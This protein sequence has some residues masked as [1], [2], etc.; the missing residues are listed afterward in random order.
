MVIHPTHSKVNFNRFVNNTHVS[1]PAQELDVE[2]YIGSSDVSSNWWGAN[3]KSN[4]KFHNGFMHDF[5]QV[6]LSAGDVSTCDINKCVNGFVPLSL[7]YHFVLNNSNDTGDFGR[8]PDFNATIML[9][10]NGLFR[11]LP[12]ME[13][14]DVNNI[15]AK[16]PWNDTLNSAGDYIFSGLVD[17]QLLNINITSERNNNTGL[18]IVKT[19][20]SSNVSVGDLVNYTINVSNNGVTN[21]SQINVNDTLNNTI[22]YISS[23]SNTGSYNSSSGL[24]SI[25]SLNV[26]EATILNINVRFK[27]EGTITNHAYL[28]LNDSLINESSV[29]VTANPY[30]NMGNNNSTATINSS[31]S[32]NGVGSDSGDGFF[33]SGLQGTGFPLLLL[34][35]ILSICGLFYWRRNS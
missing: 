15:L 18:S 28:L 5:Y 9:N 33:G 35:V 24:W 16:N 26:G 3:N 6:E 14:G 25:P 19:V 4:A 2:T 29:N 21:L 22:E 27:S 12:F 34:V 13:H 8:L 1:D 31:N 10:N 20:N 23:E 7:G 11:F 32:N 30:N 17:N